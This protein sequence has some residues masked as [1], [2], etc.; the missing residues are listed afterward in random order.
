MDPEELFHL[1][2]E[3]VERIGRIRHIESGI[4]LKGEQVRKVVPKTVIRGPD[5]LVRVVE[6]LPVLIEGLL[7]K[8]VLPFRIPLVEELSEIVLTD[9]RECPSDRQQ[10]PSRLKLR[11]QREIPS[12][13][14]FLMKVTHLDGNVGKDLSHAF[15]AVEDDG[16]K[17]K[18]LCF[19]LFP[20]F[21]VHC[22]IF[23]ADESPEDI[24]PEL[25]RPED[26]H[27]VSA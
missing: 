7:G 14:R 21:S 8:K 1:A 26:K 4:F 9:E 27:T 15:S 13:Y 16:L 23:S 6:M 3:S 2:E 5:L 10:F 19:Q 17:D 22:R 18:S 20:C 25:R 12:Q 24:L 11:F